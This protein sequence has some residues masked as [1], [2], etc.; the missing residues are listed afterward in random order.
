MKQISIDT[1]RP[2]KVYVGDNLINPHSIFAEVINNIFKGNANPKCLVVTD[3]IVDRLHFKTIEDSLCKLNINYKKNVLQNGEESKNIREYKKI[4]DALAEHDLK[5]NDLVIAYGG[6]VIGDISGFAASTWLRGIRYIQIPTTL[7]SMV[8]SSVGGKCAIDIEYGKN[9]VGSF[10]Q[11]SAVITN[12]NFLDTLPNNILSDGMSE[13]IKSAILKSPELFAHLEEKGFN[14]D[15]EYVV[16][17]TIS[18]KNYFVS[19][20]EKENGIRQMLNLGHTIAHA[21]EKLSDYKIS[22]GSAVAIGLDKIAYLSSHYGLLPKSS[23]DRIH[24]LIIKFSLPFDTDFS[25]SQMID[26]I[27]I[28]KKTHGNKINII[29]P[30]DIGLCD[31]KTIELSELD[32]YFK[33]L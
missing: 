8:D 18:I 14:F 20:D 13:V 15:K 9:L 19:N 28:D 32:T 17:E 33:P 10:W 22:H 23:Y 30:K 21:I 16:S 29:I 4:I 27:K 1:S 11:P 6:G 26:I 25:I 5:K 12:I 24:N 2:Y 31:I 3:D 7:L